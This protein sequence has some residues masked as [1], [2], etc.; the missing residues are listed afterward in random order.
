MSADNVMDLIAA[1][2]EVKRPLVS[3]TT[4]A[5]ELPEWDSL[6]TMNILLA[7]QRE[8]GLRLAP[9]ETGRLQSVEGVLSLL[10]DAGKL[11]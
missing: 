7:L 6:G 10:R 8:F 1:T 9:G 3:T 4:V 2:L 5:S 11:S